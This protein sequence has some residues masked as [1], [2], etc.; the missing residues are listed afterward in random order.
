MGPW[1]R[2]RSPP[3]SEEALPAAPCLL[4]GVREPESPWPRALLPGGEAVT[5]SHTSALLTR[6]FVVVDIVLVSA[7]WTR[8]NTSRDLAPWG[9]LGLRVP[10]LQLW[11]KPTP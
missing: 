11:G 5:V 2:R 1:L 4:H 9:N 8:L 7:V 3:T 10:G 6:T